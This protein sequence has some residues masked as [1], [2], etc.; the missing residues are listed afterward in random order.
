MPRSLNTLEDTVNW[1]KEAVPEPNEKSFNVQLGVHVEEFGEMLQELSAQTPI[2][3]ELVS[4]ALH[5]VEKLAAFLKSTTK[6]VIV[7]EE[8]RLGFLDS[9]CDQLVTAAGTGY[10]AGMDPVG[11]LAEVNRSNWSKFVD[12]KAVFDENRKIAKGPDYSK[13]D[14]TPFV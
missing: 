10:Q 4:G 13:A 8:N 5:S 12:D 14:L 1:F 2:G 11:G 6:G 7:Q 9:I 3:Q